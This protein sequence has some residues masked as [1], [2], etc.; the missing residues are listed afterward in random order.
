MGELVGI[1]TR[2]QSGAGPWVETL[3]G[4]VRVVLVALTVF[5]TLAVFVTLTRDTFN[6]GAVGTITG[7]RVGVG[8]SAPCA[9]W[10]CEGDND[11]EKVE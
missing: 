6:T 9:T 1:P 3:A 7:E 4:D 5:V 2:V 8:C 11:N 10:D